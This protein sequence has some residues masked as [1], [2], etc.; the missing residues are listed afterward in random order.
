TIAALMAISA[1]AAV[2]AA[3][4]AGLYYRAEEARVE[5]ARDEIRDLTARGQEAVKTGAWERADELLRGAR[6]K[7]RAE[8]ALA[9]ADGD[10]EALLAQV[11]RRLDA[12]DAYRR[13]V[14][15]R[16]EALFHAT[17]AFGDNAAE[18]RTTA[19]AKAH[20]ALAAVGAADASAGWAP[21]DALPED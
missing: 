6:D 1:L 5:A 8:P 20:E 21:A 12:R 19:Q 14:G 7:A 16:D 15:L 2:V 4:A 9:G 3:A 17:L 10:A 11:R 18:N 13:F